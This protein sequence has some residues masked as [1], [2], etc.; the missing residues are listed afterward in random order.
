VA[1][2]TDAERE[3]LRGQLR[4]LES[5]SVRILSRPGTYKR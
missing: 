3:R 2:A 4:E 1:A 5:W